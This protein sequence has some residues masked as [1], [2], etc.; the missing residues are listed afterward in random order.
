MDRETIRELAQIEGEPAVSILCPLDTQRPGNRQDPAVLAKLRDQ[1]VETV[2]REL[3]GPAAPSLIARIDE[4]VDSVDLQH[5]SRGVAILVTATVSR[6]V[7]LDAPV[8]PD[9]VVGKKFAIR[10]LVTA[11]SR[12]KRARAIVLSLAKT[13]CIDITGDKVAERRSLG[14][15]VEVVPPAEADT[16]HGDF[17]LSEHERAEATKY[18]FRAVDRALGALQR[19]DRLPVVLVGTTRDLAYFEEVTEEA[20]SIVG[21]I[22]G[23]HERSTPDEIA[24]LATPAIEL[25]EGLVQ[26]R[27]CDEARE[28]IGTHAVS[29]IAETWLAARTGRGHQLVVEDGYRYPAHVIA[30]A[31]QPT[32]SDLVAGSFDAVADTVEEVVGHDGEVVVV[33]SGSLA[34]LGHIALLTRY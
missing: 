7:A 10:D 27:M 23:N 4:A 33:P 15:P 34:D 11:M 20:T 21:R 8:E 14:F 26:E 31:L 24:L 6:V 12:T 32:A 25:H 9:V 2:E 1:A 18:V 13:R 17:P 16:P 5:P 19:H 22:A 28:A 3:R 29:G 30:E